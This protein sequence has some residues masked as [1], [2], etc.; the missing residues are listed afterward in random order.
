MTEQIYHQHCFRCT[1]CKRPLS[2]STYVED[3]GTKRLYCLP[4]YKQLAAAAG[5]SA[6][7]TGGV[8]QSAGVL[9]EKKEKVE[10]QEEVE[11]VVVGS[12]V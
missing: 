6:V 9:V 8:D 5:L 2:S 3:A 10:E 11:Q 1:K 12:A 7:A 4:H